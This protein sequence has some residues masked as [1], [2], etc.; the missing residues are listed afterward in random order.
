MNFSP[1]QI[2]SVIKSNF[3]FEN[4]EIVGRIP[5]GY[6][7]YT[8]EIKSDGNT[9][10]FQIWAN[11]NEQNEI[12][13]IYDYLYP[14]GI[15]N[16][17]CINKLLADLKIKTPQLYFVDTSKT[18]IPFDCSLSQYIEIDCYSGVEKHKK[19]GT[20]KQFLREFGNSFAK[21]K[22]FSRK[23][24]GI[25]SS[26][27]SFNPV[28][29]V[30]NSAVDHLKRPSQIDFIKN[31]GEILMDKLIEL[32]E[33]IK[34]R[35]IHHLIHCDFK[36]DNFRFDETGNVFWTDFKTIQFFDIEYE[37]SQFVI[38]DFMIT[39]CDA[40][41][42]KYFDSIQIEIDHNRLAFYKF[43]RCITQIHGCS[44]ALNNDYDN[45]DLMQTIINLDQVTL[46]DMLCK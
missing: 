6:S 33:N 27:E 4:I 8:Y 5:G 39:N 37:I 1:E 45:K 13:N 31:N 35:N 15:D 17:C 42:E 29:V 26:S 12:T 44:I 41:F 24:A 21:L 28:E 19:N 18:I 43:V 10:I 9:Y 11:P 20:Y 38:P 36:P 25:F 16:F 40:F 32:K 34:F 3:K 14:G 2:Q 23:E 46:N 7:K 30:F 22:Q